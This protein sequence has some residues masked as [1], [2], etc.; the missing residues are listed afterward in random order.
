MRALETI[1]NEVGPSLLHL[2][3]VAHAKILDRELVD[4]TGNLKL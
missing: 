3:E 4:S 2:L 1:F